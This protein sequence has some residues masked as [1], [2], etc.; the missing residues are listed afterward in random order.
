MAVLFDLD[1][2]LV[3]SSPVEPLRRDR[4]WGDVYALIPQVRPYPGISE[5]LAEL[6]SRRIPVCVVTSTPRPYCTRVIRHLGWNIDVSVCYHDTTK[7]KPDP[8]P[9]LLALSKLGVVA[10]EAVAVGDEPRDIVAARA[11]GISSVAALWGSLDRA[12]LI[13]S[14]PDEVCET[15]HD[16]RAIL[17]RGIG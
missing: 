10:S 14:Q 3:D 11:A 12:Q 16:L 8:D 6:R 1:Q 7:H 2:T 9:M 17:L 13:A 4:R 5:L 15:V